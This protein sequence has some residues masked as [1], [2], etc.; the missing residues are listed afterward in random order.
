MANSLDAV[1][2]RISD[3]TFFRLAR[4][5]SPVRLALCFV[6]FAGTSG[7]WVY[8]LTHG[9]I[10][11]TG[12]QL[13]WLLTTTWAFMTF[14]DAILVYA[15]YYLDAPLTER[16]YH[17]RTHPVALQVTWRTLILLKLSLLL[18]FA[19]LFIVVLIHLVH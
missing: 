7:F 9:D 1:L 10:S 15:R 4:E 17:A 6:W 3:S 16:P 18:G 12:E 14:I 8:F 2:V 5:P 13:T 11:S 19:A